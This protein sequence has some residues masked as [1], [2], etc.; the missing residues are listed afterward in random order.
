MM[1]VAHLLRSIDDLRIAWEESNQPVPPISLLSAVFGAAEAYKRDQ[2]KFLI[3]GVRLTSPRVVCAEEGLLVRYH[4]PLAHILAHSLSP[5]RELAQSQARTFHMFF[6]AMAVLMDAPLPDDH[7]IVI[8]FE[9]VSNAA[10][11][12]VTPR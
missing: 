6:K 8:S 12:W 9:L 11:D 1:T 5:A 2:Q 10:T 4:G 7:K 3:D